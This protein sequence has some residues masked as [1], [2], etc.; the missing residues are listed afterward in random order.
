MNTKHRA[1]WIPSVLAVAGVAVLVAVGWWLISWSGQA[2]EAKPGSGIEAASRSLKLYY[3]MD[4]PRNF[5]TESVRV[6]ATDT[7]RVQVKQL[8]DQF[9]SREANTDLEVWPLP[10][11]I[12]AVYLR[13]GGMLVVDFEKPVQYNQAVSAQEELLMV[14]SLLKTL[15][16]NFPEVKTARFLI[17]GQEVETLAGH[18]DISRTLSLEDFV[19]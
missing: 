11:K 5:R 1:E 7:F 4:S 16:A 8:L 17:G 14:R 3:A 9:V 12:R 6:S 19:W 2:R 13:G 15:T 18:V 10:L